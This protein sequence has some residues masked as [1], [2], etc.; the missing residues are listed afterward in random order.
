MCTVLGWI[1]EPIQTLFEASELNNPC[2]ACKALGD[3]LELNKFVLKWI[4]HLF[5]PERNVEL[6]QIVQALKLHP[7]L[8][9]FDAFNQNPNVVELWLIFLLLHI[10]QDVI[11][12][13]VSL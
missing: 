5:M 1:R 4:Q 6:S 9:V 8:L 3:I 13:M 10:L 12:T 11:A 2:V 7:V